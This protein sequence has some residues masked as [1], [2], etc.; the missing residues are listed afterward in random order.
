[1]A[2]RL[3]VYFFF[4]S[5]H[6]NLWIRDAPP[7]TRWRLPKLYQSFR[8]GKKNSR[9]SLSCN[10]VIVTKRHKL[11]FYYRA[12]FE[13]LFLDRNANRDNSTFSS[14]T[15]RKAERKKTNEKWL[16]NVLS[17]ERQHKKKA[18]QQHWRHQHTNTN[19]NTMK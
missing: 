2:N 14:S 19:A 18:F 13:S 1:M 10:A 9:F 11:W 17:V 12:T 7:F 6:L 8:W 16:Q 15:E 3:Y 5:F 4:H